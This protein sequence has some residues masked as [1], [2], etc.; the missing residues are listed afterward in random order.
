MNG[1]GTTVKAV[2]SHSYVIAFLN[3][4]DN[5]SELFSLK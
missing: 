3:L 4:A 5:I 2:P 1:K